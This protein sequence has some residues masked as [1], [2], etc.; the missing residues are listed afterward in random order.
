MKKKLLFVITKSVWGGA[1]RYVYDLAIALSEEYDVAVALGGSGPLI[2]K[3]QTGGVRTIAIPS[4]DRDI[5]TRSDSSAFFELLT[6]FKKEKPD[7]VHVNSSKAG[8]LGALAARI[9][10]VPKIVYTAH[11]WAFNEPVSP[12]SKLFRWTVSLGTLLLSHAVITVSHFDSIHSPLGLE[13]TMIHNGLASPVFLP[14]GEA[15]TE[16]ALRGGIP[17]DVFIVGTIAELNKNKGVVTLIEAFGQTENSHLIVIGEGEDRTKLEM[18]VA[19][20][21]LQSRVHLV[22]FIENAAIFLKAFDMFVLASRKEGL[23]YVILEAGAAE[24]PTVATIVGGIPEIIDDQ[25]SG[26]LVPPYDSEMLAEALSEL[27]NSP[28]TRVRYGSRLKE[29]V[30]RHFPL[31]GM[32]KKTIEVYES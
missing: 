2:S 26:I 19:R 5:D 6:I 3:L 15:R 29:K 22:G 23:P 24:V 9:Q 18:L 8:A 1:G 20:H 28:A 31:R 30:E 14:K 25:L 21:G 32:I 12:L 7:I 10:R 17:T 11:G 13:T 4:L 16:L 27:I